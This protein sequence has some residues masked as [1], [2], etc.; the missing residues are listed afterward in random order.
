[1]V[2]PDERLKRNKSNH[3]KAILNSNNKTI[4]KVLNNSQINSY[5]RTNSIKYFTYN[6]E[7]NLSKMDPRIFRNKFTPKIQ[8]I[9][10]ESKIRNELIN[11][12][13]KKEK[14]FNKK[15]KI[16]MT[17]LKST[18]PRIQE[19]IGIF[20]TEFKQNLQSQIAIRKPPTRTMEK[21]V[22]I[23]A[24]SSTEDIFNF[25]NRDFSRSY[26][27][28]YSTR[29]LMLKKSRKS[30][31]IMTSKLSKDAKECL[32]ELSSKKKRTKNA[33]VLMYSRKIYLN[34]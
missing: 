12:I 15:E 5:K 32:V 9:Y 1:M 11:N 10:N 27:E 25:S 8:P 2:T 6:P 24:S 19:K 17:I 14:S 21:A 7:N 3:F 18:L 34:K 26:I 31:K 28:E 29:N 22:Q 23:D 13:I 20:D 33:F 30:F 16:K 4:S